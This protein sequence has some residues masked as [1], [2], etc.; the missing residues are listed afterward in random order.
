MILASRDVVVMSSNVQKKFGW[1]FV[2]RLACSV[3]AISLCYRLSVDSAAFGESRLF[4]TLSIIQSRVEPSDSAVRLTPNDPEAHYTRALALV[5]FERLPEAVAELNVALR[6]R[7]HHYYQWLDLGVTLDRL[8]DQTGATGALRES[9]RLAPFFA[10]PRWQLGNLLYRQGRFQEAFEQLRLGAASNPRLIAN[11]IEMAWVASAGKNEVLESLVQPRSQ[12][13]HLELAAVMVREGMAQDAVRQLE[14]AGNASDKE[15]IDLSRQIVSQLLAN[16]RFTEAYAAWAINHVGA[17]VHGN[18]AERFVNGDFHDPVMQDDP[19]FGWQLPPVP[20]V[21]RSIDPAGPVPN[22]RSIRIEYSGESPP[23][24][25][26]ISELLLVQPSTRYTVS[27]MART[28]RLVSGGPPVI[29]IVDA[30]SKA[31]KVLGQSNAFP[32]NTSGWTNY[33][34]E[35]FTEADIHAVNVGLQRLACKETPCPIFGNLWLA[36][37]AL[38]RS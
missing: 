23:G 20:S 12:R 9:I 13:S 30:R 14:E 16:E 37:F 24:N 19:G 17:G 15:A 11:V 29:V 18:P 8:G 34:M 25:R 38:A 5:N 10:Q 4:S 22:A 36:K 26:V 6:L 21:S 27:F 32:S 28:D 3:V 7:P 1:R 35:F 31:P 33:S 2:L